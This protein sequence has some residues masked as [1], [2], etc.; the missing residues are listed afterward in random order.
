MKIEVYG[1]K[2]EQINEGDIF[3]ARITTIDGKRAVTLLDENEYKLE[4]SLDDFDR[5]SYK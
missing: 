4:K 2:A 3:K 1:P 5:R